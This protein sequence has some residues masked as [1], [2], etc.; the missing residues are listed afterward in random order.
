MNAKKCF[1]GAVVIGLLTMSCNQ[2]EDITEKNEGTASLKITLKSSSSELKSTG[3]PTQAQE[4]KINTFTVYVYNS[5]SSFLENS[6][7]FTP[8]TSAEYTQ[9]ISGL[10]TGPKKVVVIANA[11]AGY[12]VVAGSSYSVLATNMFD[13]STQNTPTSL[14][15]SG[16]SPITLTTAANSLSVN[17]SR[18][19]AKIQLGTVTIAPEAGYTGTFVLTKVHIMKA[20]GTSTMG[21]PTIA[22]G[23]NFYGG[24]AGTVS[25][26]QKAFLSETYSGTINPATNPIYFYVFPNDNTSSNATL[27]TLEGTY[28]GTTTYFPFVI[29]DS[30]TGTG[31]YITRN[32]YYT[33][34][35]TIKRTGNGSSNPEIPVEPAALDITIV[36]INWA[37]VPTQNV[38]W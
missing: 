25:L 34:N 27:L 21:V 3:L 4:S 15:M 35:V 20:K 26:T 1:F 30:Y 17:I 29:N 14:T 18:V 33:I 11:P 22:T 31:S 38:T 6:Q 5:V 37:I 10:S 28:D 24:V 8:A 19:V 9:T 32:S 12:N 16:E 36:P 7:T 13:L 2:N 23:S